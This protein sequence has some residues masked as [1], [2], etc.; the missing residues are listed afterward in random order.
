MAYIRMK[1]PSFKK[2]FLAAMLAMF[3]SCAA[4]GQE[5]T[6][7]PQS[8]TPEQTT[9]VATTLSSLANQLPSFLDRIEFNGYAQAAYVYQDAG[10]KTKST[11]DL[12]RTLLWA[13][14]KITD[15]WSF[16]FMHD[17]NSEVQ[18]FY[19]DY[20]ISKG[21]QLSVRVGQFKNSY[22]LENPLSPTQ[23]ELIDVYSQ[24]VTYLAGCGSDP[25]YGVNYGRDLGFMVFGDLF[26]N[27]LHYELA[28]MNGQG[29]N[30]SDG[31]SDKDIILKLEYRL[32]PELRV[33]V[34]GQKGRGNAVGTADWNPDI[35]VGDNYTRD[36]L[37]LGG[38]WKD[39]RIGLHG[40]WLWG[41]D[42]SVK[43]RGAYI[44]GRYTVVKN[45]DVIASADF[46]D[47]NT[48]MEYDQTNLTTGIQYWY[49]RKCRVQLQY[50]R[51]LC[52]AQ[53]DYNCVQAQV[54]VAF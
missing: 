24:A 52:Q 44:T 10:D 5:K 4:M 37:S 40:E 3:S 18:E 39:D 15:R 32:R 12:K 9:G 2:A 41:K 19:T 25:L 49:F 23:M 43:S 11:L 13:K 26:K 22:S 46:F 50:T 31:N 17:F 20:R 21:K 53:D 30:C 33:V 45:F 38:E 35:E 27:K 1:K 51:A 36:R 14:A 8:P 29:I 28:V 34:S 6:E 47:K 48:R 16:L 7:T 54:Q 42:G